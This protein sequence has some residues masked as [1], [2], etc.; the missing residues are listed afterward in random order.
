MWG[1][2]AGAKV[3]LRR[4]C[5]GG[6]E[7]GPRTSCAGARASTSPTRWATSC[8]PDATGY[9]PTSSRS[10]STTR[11]RASPRSSGGM[12]S[13]RARAPRPRCRAPTLLS[14]AL[15]E[16][17]DENGKQ[18]EPR[19]HCIPALN[20]SLGLLGSKVASAVRATGPSSS[21][22]PFRRVLPA[23]PGT[24]PGPGPRHRLCMHVQVRPYRA[25]WAL[26][27]ISLLFRAQ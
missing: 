15:S 6:A 16:N 1:S 4:I 13:G 20:N 17:I 8:S 14:S 10:S 21:R 5:A 22:F 24:G 23:W 12:T 25:R 19:L 26:Y 18:T 27:F 11:A 7:E 3:E 9:G 2:R